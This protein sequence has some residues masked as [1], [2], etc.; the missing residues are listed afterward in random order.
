MS[1]DQKCVEARSS[2]WA[3][4]LAWFF[5]FQAEDGIRDTSVTGVQTCALPIY[6]VDDRASARGGRGPRGGHHRARPQDPDAAA[7]DQLP[8]PRS[9]LRPRLRAQHGPRSEERR[10]GKEW[11]SPE[12]AERSK[13]KTHKTAEYTA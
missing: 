3:P 1:G 6:Q 12:C 2:S 4:V 9:G 10:V 13:E 11:R 5:F 8:A 7:D